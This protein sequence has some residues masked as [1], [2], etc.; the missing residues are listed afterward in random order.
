MLSLLL[1]QLVLNN[2]VATY[3][4]ILMPKNKAATDVRMLNN[5]TKDKFATDPH[6]LTKTIFHAKVK[7]DTDDQI[8]IINLSNF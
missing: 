6:L 8:L 5:D 3:L 4:Q 1:L 7:V 2:K